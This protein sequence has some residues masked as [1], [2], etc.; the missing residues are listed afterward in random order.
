MK[1]GPPIAKSSMGKEAKKAESPFS[2]P[3]TRPFNEL[4]QV[5]NGPQSAP[6]P[7]STPPAPSYQPY[8][9]NAEQTYA[10]PPPVYQA[11]VSNAGQT[12]AP[13]PPVYQTYESSAGQTYASYPQ[14]RPDS[15]Q[16]SQTQIPVKPSHSGP[17]QTYIDP[18]RQPPR[19]KPYKNE[20]EDAT[21]GP[22]KHKSTCPV[23]DI[24]SRP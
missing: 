19:L 11:Y 7:V 10:P 13:T 4:V 5:V 2:E 18:Q 3:V 17:A 8:V 23:Q 6:P 1:R 21:I 16:V 20:L 24:S 9:S 14:A 22:L 15:H 12:Y